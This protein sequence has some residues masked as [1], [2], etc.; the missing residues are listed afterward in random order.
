MSLR[1]WFAGQALTGLL[2]NPN[3]ENNDKWSWHTGS[4]TGDAYQ[5]A[6]DMLAE[7]EQTK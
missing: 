4:L 1:D 6:D 3:R 5:Y 7:R 2:A